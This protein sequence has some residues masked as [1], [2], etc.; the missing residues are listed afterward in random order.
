MSIAMQALDTT[1]VTD[2]K[3]D[4]VLLTQNTKVGIAIKGNF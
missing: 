3:E 2:Q 4:P 1:P